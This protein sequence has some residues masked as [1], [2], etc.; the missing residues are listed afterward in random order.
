MTL[1]CLHQ[2]H[3][4]AGPKTQCRMG[5]IPRNNEPTNWSQSIN[6]VLGEAVE[7]FPNIYILRVQFDHF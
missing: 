4:D 2:I 6:L 1:A 5:E 3:H 7:H